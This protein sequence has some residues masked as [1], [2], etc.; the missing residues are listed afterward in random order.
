[1]LIIPDHII[2]VAIDFEDMRDA[3]ALLC[4]W[5]SGETGCTA[6]A[7]NVYECRLDPRVTPTARIWRDVLE[8]VLISTAAFDKH[9]GVA[10]LGSRHVIEFLHLEPGVG[11]VVSTTVVGMDGHLIESAAVPKEIYETWSASALKKVLPRLRLAQPRSKHSLEA[12]KSPVGHNEARQICR[13]S[14]TEKKQVHV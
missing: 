14:S 12:R 3:V 10:S 6:D 13:I 5:Y 1:M 11:S 8:G 4:R 2:T 7:L 9:P